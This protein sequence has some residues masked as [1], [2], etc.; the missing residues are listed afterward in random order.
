MMSLSSFSDTRRRRR[1]AFYWRLMKTV[2]ALGALL[3]VG[4]YSYQVGVSASQA[5]ST[6]LE[7]DLERFQN[8]NLELRDRLALSIQRSDQA[9]SAQETLRQRYARDVPQ[10]DLA[11]LMAQVAA[12]RAA[13]AEIE[14]LAFLID[15]AARPPA[16]AGKPS[17]KRFMPRTAV[18]TGP[19]SFVRFDERVTVTG[20]G[21]PLRNAEGLPEA[22]FDPARP[23][24]LDFRTLDG[25]VVTVVGVVPLTHRMVAGEREY[26]FSVVAG[27]RS[28]VEITGQACSMPQQSTPEPENADQP[29]GPD[30]A[31]L[32]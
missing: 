12:Q 13:G 31:S 19:V 5:R 17:T 15:A 22:W 3:A 2:V 8:S 23:I 29:F 25:E 1:R 4:G 9:E 24:R 6:K 14:R 27:E 16:C 18:S 7:V 30:E 28:F 26:R 10:G 32:G 21:E 20:A 11:V